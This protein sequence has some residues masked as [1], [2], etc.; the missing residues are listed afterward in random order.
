MRYTFVALTAFLFLSAASLAQDEGARDTADKAPESTLRSY[1]VQLTEFRWKGSTDPALS[2]RVIVRAVDQLRKDGKLDVIETVRLSALEN[3]ESMAQFGKSV[4]MTTG[5][6]DTRQG[7]V[8]NVDFQQ[9]GTMV[10]LT[11]VPKDGKVVLELQYEASRLNGEGAGDLPPSTLTTQFKT[12]PM[13]EPGTPTSIWPHMSREHTLL[14]PFFSG[15]LDSPLRGWRVDAGP[16]SRPS[17]YA[18]ATG[19]CEETR[20]RSGF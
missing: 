2:P 19:S 16:R 1:V 6:A 9:V 15:F 3:H 11:A 8:R 4:P 7:R 13:I 12:T 18:A 5:V 20:D 14:V 17:R 10:K